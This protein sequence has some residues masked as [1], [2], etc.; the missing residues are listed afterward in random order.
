MRFH[1]LDR[2][3]EPVEVAVTVVQ[4]VNDTDVTGAVVFFQILADGDEILRFAAPAAVIVESEP[5]TGFPCALDDRQ[6]PRRRGLDPLLL[7]RF[8]AAAESDP[9]LRMEI[10]LFKEAERLFVRAPEGEELDPVFLVGEDLALELRD[11]FLPPIVGD[12]LDPHLRDHL[13]PFL[14]GAL[15]RIERDDAPGG[16]V[17]FVEKVGSRRQHGRRDQEQGCEKSEVRFHG[18]RCFPT[19]SGRPTDWRR[20]EFSG[21]YLEFKKRG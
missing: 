11:M 15:L 7:G 21:S 13:G 5:A 6:H 14:G 20:K 9:D 18:R 12:L 19:D 8:V 10:V 16:E 4:V 2:R 1:Q 17:G 3:G